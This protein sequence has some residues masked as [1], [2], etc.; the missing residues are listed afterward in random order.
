MNTSSTFVPADTLESFMY[1]VFSSLGFPE[2]AALESAHTLIQADLRGIDSH[3]C[4]RLASYIRLIDLKRI[5]P[6]AQPKIIRERPATALIDADAG[7]G[8]WIGK[9]A[10]EIA[11]N[12][13]RQ[14]GSAWIGVKNSSHFGIGAA[15][16]LNTMGEDMIAIAMTNASP[17][18]APAGATKPYLGTNPMCYAIPAGK[19]QPIMADLATSVVAN[20]KLEV[21][22]RAG[23]P[24]PQGWAQDI[25]GNSSTDPLVLKSGGTMLPLGSDSDHSYHKGYALASV[26]DIFSG[27]LTGANFGS[28]VPPFVPFLDNKTETVGEGI[29]H[30]FGAISIDAFMEI[31]DYNKRIEKWIEGVKA[32][33]PKEGVEEVL[34]PGEPE[35]RT[36]QLRLS[37]GIEISSG[38]M[39][40]L[41][42]M[43]ARFGLS[44]L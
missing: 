25:D 2:Y 13:A 11:V 1:Q 31:S 28:W 3:G 14:C 24:I 21:A 20:G 22:H 19:Y 17:L 23:K 33:P 29:G 34:I 39:E 44:V 6:R 16:C 40:D 32:I 42:A 37:K 35:Y 9:E 41:L 12:K 36:S 18:M 15:H 43:Q 5:N 8:L 27:V 4:A 30:W 38:L 7:L 26:V 10:M